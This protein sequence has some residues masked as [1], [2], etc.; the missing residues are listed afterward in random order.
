MFFRPAHLL[1]LLV[2][3][4]APAA[5]CGAPGEAALVQR[6]GLDGEIAFATGRPAR[7]GGLALSPE[8]ADALKALGHVRIVELGAAPDRWGRRI[9]DLV[10]D[11]GGSIALDLVLRGL[12][13]V[14]PEPETASCDAE[15][16]EAEGAARAAGEGVWARADAILDAEDAVGLAAADGRFV[17]VSGTVQRVGARSASVYLELAR[18]RGFAVVVAR[19][20]EPRFRR[21]GL[22]LASLAGRRLLVRG[23]LDTRFGPRIEVADP[24]MIEPL[25]SPKETG[26]GG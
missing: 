19:K 17:F 26:R 20:A 6:A 5:A 23:V 14:R 15:R 3:L 8:A 25:E 16:L 18:A 2:G 13:R 21:A 12:A 22:D 4:S 11:G 10:D 1:C 9:V 7:W 24:S